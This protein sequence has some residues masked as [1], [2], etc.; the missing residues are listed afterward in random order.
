MAPG[1]PPAVKFFGDFGDLG[2]IVRPPPYPNA[3]RL[4]LRLAEKVTVAFGMNLHD[5]PKPHPN[6][7]YTQPDAHHR[8]DPGHGRHPPTRTQEA[9]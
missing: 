7:T 5:R 4:G 8:V 2:P 9:A 1:V 6:D 3:S